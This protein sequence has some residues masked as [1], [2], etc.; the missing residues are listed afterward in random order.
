MKKKAVFLDYDERNAQECNDILPLLVT[1]RVEGRDVTEA[2]EFWLEHSP[3]DAKSLEKLYHKQL[4]KE[5]GNGVEMSEKLRGEL[6][7]I[8]QLEGRIDIND[9]DAVMTAYAKDCWLEDVLEESIEDEEMQRRRD[10]W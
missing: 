2:E 4:K 6:N 5:Y 1:Y 8:A 9:R 10:N 3:V 7:M